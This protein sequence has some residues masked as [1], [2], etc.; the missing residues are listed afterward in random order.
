MNKA[1]MHQPLQSVIQTAVNDTSKLDRKPSDRQQR[2]SE[3]KFKFESGTYH[4]DLT[5]LA[6]RITGVGVL[7]QQS[8]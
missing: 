4:V 2:I 1:D 7:E 5:K 3:L 6:Q 8:E